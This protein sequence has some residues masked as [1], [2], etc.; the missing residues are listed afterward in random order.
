[1]SHPLTDATPIEFADLLAGLPAGA[2]PPVVQRRWLTIPSGGHVSGV[3]WHTGAPRVLL[4]HEAGASARTWDDVLTALGRPAV[5]VDLP[6]HGRSTWR[7][8]GDYRPRRLAASVAEA[9][10]SFAPA[11][12]PVV[13]RGLGALVAVAATAK[14]PARL[15]RLVLV[16]TLPG[17][18]AAADRP[19]PTP[20]PDFADQ[21]EAHAWLTA[22]TR[23]GAGAGPGTDP[24]AGSAG[25]PDAR[26][27]R[28]E[29]TQGDD[30]RWTWRHHLGALPDGAPT[31]LD[32][33]AL[34]ARLAAAPS[35]LLVRT[36]GGPLDDKAVARFTGE[37]PTGEAV[38]VEPGPAA[39]AALLRGLLP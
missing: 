15:G 8:R 31:D 38:T 3:F 11:D 9:A 25:R 22:R 33:E 14:A 21:D 37:V 16:D 13:G 7:G 35:P 39:L 2:A 19:W 20:S 23:A 4:L 30:G 24:G 27:A 26:T 32:D 6:G 34:W 17:S 10:H 5:A 12:V 28:Q 29:T 1:M 18:P 36:Q